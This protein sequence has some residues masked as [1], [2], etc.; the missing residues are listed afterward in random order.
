[1]EVSETL[2][3]SSKFPWSREKISS[4]FIDSLG[5]RAQKLS[6]ALL[7]RQMKISKFRFAISG[8]KGGP[9]EKECQ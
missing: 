1:M 7:C 2:C 5:T 3:G 9:M 6:P 4:K 8:R